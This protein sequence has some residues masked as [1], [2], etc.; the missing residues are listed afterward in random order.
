MLKHLDIDTLIERSGIRP[1]DSVWMKNCLLGLTDHYLIY[2]GR[3]ENGIP[4]F[5][6]RM[7]FGMVELTPEQI[8]YLIG[9]TYAARVNQLDCEEAHRVTAVRRME[10]RMDIITYNLILRNSKEFKEE[11][12]AAPK[13]NWKQIPIGFGVT[14]GVLGAI[15]LGIEAWKKW[16]DNKDK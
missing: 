10:D 16:M 1:G 5:V 8:A 9:N 2:L 14:L 7:E 4:T 6:G 13:F 3:N 15:Y 11:V 12:K